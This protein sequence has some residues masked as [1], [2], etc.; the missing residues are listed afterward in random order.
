MRYSVQQIISALATAERQG[1]KTDEP[2]GSR[3]ILLSDTLAGHFAS[4]LRSHLTEAAS[5]SRQE[6][7]N[8]AASKAAEERAAAAV[9]AAK[10]AEFEKSMAIRNLRSSAGLH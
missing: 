2:E 3:F 9:E 7:A 1:S 5:A 4:S 6:A 10:K 8:K